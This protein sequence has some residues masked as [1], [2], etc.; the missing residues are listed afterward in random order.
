MVLDGVTLG[1]RSF[2]Q[3]ESPGTS[4]LGEDSPLPMVMKTSRSDTPVAGCP[5]SG[6]H[7]CSVSLNK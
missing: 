4:R 2:P 3:D 1:E 7:G 6:L 5:L